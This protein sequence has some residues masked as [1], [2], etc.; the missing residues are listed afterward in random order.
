METENFD[1]KHK[2]RLKKTILMI[3]LIILLLIGL[4]VFLFYKDIIRLFA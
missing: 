1:I 4:M 2:P 3:R